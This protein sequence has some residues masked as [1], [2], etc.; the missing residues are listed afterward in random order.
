V[1]PDELVH[2][3]DAVFLGELRHLVE[4]LESEPVAGERGR[5]ARLDDLATDAAQEVANDREHA[6]V[7]ARVRDQLA[8]DDRRR[9]IEQV[10]AE[11][12]RGE[13]GTAFGAQ[14]RDRKPRRYGRDDRVGQ[15]RAE[16]IER[17]E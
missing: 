16:P 8:A 12:V 15:A 2:E 9:R 1:R 4:H 5:V 10:D 7:G 6:R 17:L 13:C 14:R 3:R 11:E